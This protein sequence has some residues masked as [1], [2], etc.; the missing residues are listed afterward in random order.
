MILA[1][2]MMLRESF[3][4]LE[5]A[6]AIES[7]V[8]RTLAAGI[9]TPDVAAPGSTVVGSLDMG[10]RIVQNLELGQQRTMPVV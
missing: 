2:A 3:G 6:A 9:R 8:A 1:A 4:L 7:A 10:R 5:V